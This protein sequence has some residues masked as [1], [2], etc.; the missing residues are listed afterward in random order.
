MTKD[1]I[2]IAIIGCGFVA[3]YYLITLPNHSNL[4]LIGVWDHQPER[5]SHF[6]SYHD[7]QA[8]DS[9]DQCL[10]DNRVE[11]VLNLT[12]PSA[13]YE[14]NKAAM[15]AGKHVYSEKPLAMSW[16][17]ILELKDIAN[18]EGRLLTSAPCSLLGEQA[19]TL[20]KAIRDNRIGEIYYIEARIDEGLTHQMAY[21][22]WK[23]IS[24]IPW[25]W[26]D[27]FEVGCTLEHAGYYLTWLTAIFGPVKRMTTFAKCLVLD[28]ETDEPLSVNAADFSHTTLEFCSGEVATLQCSI[29]APH[30]RGLYIVG[31]KGTLS[32]DDC[33]FFDTPIMLH[34]QSKI[35]KFIEWASPITRRLSRLPGMAELLAERPKLIPPVRKASF[36]SAKSGNRMD[37]ARGPADLANALLTD[38]SVKLTMN[39]A[40]HV[41]EIALTMQYPE[42]MGRVRELQSTFEPLDPMIWAQD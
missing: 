27:E 21:R 24:G 3:D 38:D 23:S 33:W 39:H 30:N 28:K 32:T 15:L 22:R 12:N 11:L 2:G 20:W 25:P 34:Q 7:T 41:N 5:L 42:T 37:F 18:R 10:A 19:Q 36:Q 6:A 9:L 29:V 17:E 8:Y 26:K 14:L 40:V 1:H 31:S 4:K 13:H 16:P 35:D